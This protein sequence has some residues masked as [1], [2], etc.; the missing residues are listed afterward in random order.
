MKREILTTQIKSP[1]FL[2]E[3][4]KTGKNE[5]KASH[6]TTRFSKQPIRTRYFG[7]VTGY[8][9]IRDQHSLIRSVPKSSEGAIRK[10]RPGVLGGRSRL[11]DF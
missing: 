7:H 9:P 8:Q 3:M 4:I 11:A 2:A 1:T 6:E 10:G 5:T